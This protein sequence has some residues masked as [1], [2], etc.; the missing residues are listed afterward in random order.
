MISRKMVINE[1]RTWIGTRFQHQGRVKRTELHDG[2]CD[3]IGF[4]LGVADRLQLKDKN[5]N[6]I[7]RHDRSDYGRIPNG[8]SFKQALHK[9]LDEVPLAEVKAGDLVLFRFDANPQHIG[10]A[11][12][13][14]YGGRGILHCYAEARKVVET[15][16]D[17][18]W[19]LMADSSYNFIY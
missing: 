12:D 10:I 15:R 11:T 7:T 2:G 13:Y 18:Q 6:L 14:I 4:V 17:E 5:G 1:A 19:L 8:E 3:C 16:L 9:H